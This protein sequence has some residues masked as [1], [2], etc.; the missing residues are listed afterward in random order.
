MIGS[1]PFATRFLFCWCWTVV[2]GWT[3]HL[4]SA[5]KISPCVSTPAASCVWSYLI[6]V[7]NQS[8]ENSPYKHCV[9]IFKK[10]NAEQ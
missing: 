5:P 7:S 2:T 8:S 1:V 6:L 10:A 4:F 9:Y 3:E